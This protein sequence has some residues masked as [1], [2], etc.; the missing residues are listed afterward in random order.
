MLGETFARSNGDVFGNIPVPLVPEFRRIS[1]SVHKWFVYY[2]EEQDGQA[3]FSKT[4]K[5]QC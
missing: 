5:V 3:D 2:H 1:S 4:R